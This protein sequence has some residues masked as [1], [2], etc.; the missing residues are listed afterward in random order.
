MLNDSQNTPPN[1]Y[2][3]LLAL[4]PAYSFGFTDADETRLVETL[5]KKYPQAVEELDSYQGLN[6]AMLHSAPQIAP[7]PSIL[8]NLLEVTTPEQNT[9]AQST[10]ITPRRWYIPAAAAAVVAILLGAN[11]VLAWIITDLQRD[12]R[13]L[14]EQVD[15]LTTL[16][17][18]VA[19]NNFVRFD[20][21]DAEDNASSAYVLCHPD[22]QVVLL[23]AQNFPQLSP[24]MAY[25]I[26]L[27][28]DEQRISGG[29]FNVDQDGNG[30]FVFNAPD[31]MRHFRYIGITTE[32]AS[33]SS[34]PTSSP[35]ARGALYDDGA[36]QPE[37]LTPT[38]VW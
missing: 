18:L 21:D 28:Q 7:P 1:E 19:E 30:T 23:R 26:W 34:E 29:L 11:I 22:E 6:N 4:L 15:A 10:V 2:E 25:Q 20:L 3:S 24:D 36:W 37:N 13:E 27:F 5:L 17:N 14:N 38:P 8:A 12:Q 32:K 9:P 35:I 31:S 16:S 33:G